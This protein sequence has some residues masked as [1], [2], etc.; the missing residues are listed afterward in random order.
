MR[1]HQSISSC[2]TRN[3]STRQTT[4]NM[5]SQ[6][7]Q[8][9]SVQPSSSGDMPSRAPQIV[10][11]PRR[12]RRRNYGNGKHNYELR[13]TAQ[14]KQ[15]LHDK[16]QISG[17]NGEELQGNMS[18]NSSWD[19][20]PD[21]SF[22]NSQYKVGGLSVSS[23]LIN[24]GDMPL[25]ST[26][27]LSQSPTSTRKLSQSPISNIHVNCSND[28]SNDYLTRSYSNHGF[29]P[30]SSDCKSTL[31]SFDPSMLKLEPQMLPS[32]DEHSITMSAG[33]MVRNLRP[34]D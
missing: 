27:K 18:P 7:V 21:N 31:S 13:N 14:R 22:S 11:V 15:R 16:L 10:P 34:R 23:E 33:P 25:T 17:L 26:R 1:F 2:P 9:A 20:S 32:N 12:Y 19:I 28:R 29:D 24:L 30:S 4:R 6:A 8:T 3:I 5:A